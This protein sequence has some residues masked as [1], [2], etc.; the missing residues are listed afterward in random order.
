M[1]CA[2]SKTELVNTI[3]APF[4]ECLRESPPVGPRALSHQQC[5]IN[6]SRTPQNAVVIRLKPGETLDMSPALAGAVA[7]GQW[8][9][10]TPPYRG[11]PRTTSRSVYSW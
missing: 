3:S 7:G 11:L 10:A 6:A 8:D 1:V 9:H 4:A 2:H 5:P